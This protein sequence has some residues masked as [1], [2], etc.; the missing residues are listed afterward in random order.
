MAKTTTTATRA[1]ATTGSKNKKVRRNPSHALALPRATKPVGHRN[2]DKG[3]TITVTMLFQKETPGSVQ[4][5]EPEF[6]ERNG[7]KIGSLYIRKSE[8]PASGAPKSIK[9]TVEL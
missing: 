1:K 2:G 4:Y 7:Y 3:K 9:V 5:A 6:L 8:L